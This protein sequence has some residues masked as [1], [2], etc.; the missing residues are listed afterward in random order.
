MF[1]LRET[2]ARG[3]LGV[4]NPFGAIPAADP[5]P[6]PPAEVVLAPTSL[7]QAAQALRIA[8]DHRLKVLVWG[9][10]NHQGYGHRTYPDVVLVT[11]SLDRVEVWEP[12]DLTLVVDAGFRVAKL[13]ERLAEH[14]QTTLLP[15]YSPTSTI[16]GAL[17]AGPERVP[18][19]PVWTP[20]GTGCWKPG[21]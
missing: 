1:R 2:G 10:G 13:E 16:G 21:R 15:T 9:G 20:A 8:T 6:L 3:R 4:K 5:E 12:E 19:I 17:A 14:R 11:T 7:E 18:A